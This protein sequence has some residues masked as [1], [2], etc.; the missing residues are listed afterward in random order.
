MS[1]AIL[2]I[3]QHANRLLGSMGH[4]CAQFSAGLASSRTSHGAAAYGPPSRP[5]GRTTAN[6][7]AF[8]PIRRMNTGARLAFAKRNLKVGD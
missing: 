2:R 5:P 6:K 1:T 7:F 8:T 3:A 4:E